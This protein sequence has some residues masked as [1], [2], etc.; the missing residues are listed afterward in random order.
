[1][2]DMITESDIEYINTNAYLPEHVLDY[3]ITMSKGEPYLF[4]SCMCY[5]KE[6]TLIFVGYPLEGLFNKENIKRTL[7]V[8]VRTLKPARLDV[9]APSC[10]IYGGERYGYVSDRYYRIRPAD[11]KIPSKVKNMVKRASREVI[12]EHSTVLSDEHKGLISIFLKGHN[13]NSET[14]Y[15]FNSMPAYVSTSKT[16][17][18]INARDVHGRLIAFDVAEF[19]SEK[20]AFYMFNVV[21]YRNLVPGVSDLLLMELINIA[22]KEG[23]VFLNLGLGINR[24]VA[25]FKEKWGGEVFQPYEYCFYQIKKRGIIDFILHGL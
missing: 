19:A 24:G 23:K 9:I 20:Y 6:D 14:K 7:E 8:A 3:G 4:D 13:V 17:R 18:V 10:D 25:F 11:L 16:A 15:I 1:M 21:D 2:P 22:E 5:R 12:V